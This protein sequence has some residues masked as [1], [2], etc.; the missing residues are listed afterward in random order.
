MQKK[1]L[2][3]LLT[4]CMLLSAFPLAI[5]AEDDVVTDVVETVAEEVT[6]PAPDAEAEEVPVEETE[7]ETTPAGEEEEEFELLAEETTEEEESVATLNAVDISDG[8]VENEEDL[9]AL[10]ATEDDTILALDF[11]LMDSITL[12]DGSV[13]SPIGSASHPFTGTFDGNDNTISGIDIVVNGRY[14]GFFGVV[15]GA[16]ITD[17]TVDGTVASDGVITVDSKINGGLIGATNGDLTVTNCHNSVD[18]NVEGTSSILSDGAGG[19]LGGWAGDCGEATVMITDCTNEGSMYATRS[20]G[21]IVGYL[22]NTSASMNRRITVKNCVNTGALETMF[23]LAG[24]IIAHVD[25]KGVSSIQILECVNEGTVI[26]GSFSAGGILGHVEK[27]SSASGV[28]T[29]MDIKNCVSTG[30]VTATTNYAGGIIGT[31]E[32]SAK[33]TYSNVNIENCYV[34]ATVSA[35][36]HPGTIIGIVR[37]NIATANGVYTLKDV[38]YAGMSDVGFIGYFGNG[39]G[40]TWTAENV[41]QASNDIFLNNGSKAFAPTVTSSQSVTVTNYITASTEPGAYAAFMA[42]ATDAWICVNGVPALAIGGAKE[43]HDWKQVDDE[44][45]A[46][47][48]G[49]TA[50]HVDDNG[51]C[52]DCGANLSCAHTNTTERVT[53]ATCTDTGLSEIVCDACGGVVAST[54]L[55]ID[56]NAHTS[57][58]TVF[59]SV[60]GGVVVAHTCC[61]VDGVHVEE[62]IIDGTIDTPAELYGLM[63]TTD[64]ETLAA[65]YT[66]GDNIDFTGFKYAPVSIGAENTQYCGTFDGDGYTITVD[67][68]GT[69]RC[70]G[71]L[72]ADVKGAT[73]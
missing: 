35:A 42:A 41:A 71:A 53:L 55:D 46:C 25:D 58:E 54:V 40:F 44:S 52:A 3:I 27:M 37:P 23:S 48:C 28:V 68:V 70:D 22:Y 67:I 9:L 57:E 14:N 66:L 62:Y 13:Q 69:D 73:I 16:T 38:Q 18:V 47:I 2:A 64:A 10:M 29:D 45:H 24:G 30:T 21:G 33:K 17:L 60:K 11:Q 72:F 51:T 59:Y 15:N 63:R 39:A 5:F 8:L 34:D 20:T 50:G 49:E 32:A 56:P 31:L 7:D 6:D 26:A 43:A 65:D 12:S 4:L 61:G 1:L 36:S 19:I